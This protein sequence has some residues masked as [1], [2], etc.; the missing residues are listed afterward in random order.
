MF[1]GCRSDSLLILLM[2]GF[3]NLSYRQE[4]IRSKF[5]LF[6]FAVKNVIANVK[7]MIVDLI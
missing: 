1:I 2:V 6:F 4:N 7:W 3:D 5:N